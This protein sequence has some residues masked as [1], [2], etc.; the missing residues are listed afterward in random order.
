MAPPLR[1]LHIP[2]PAEGNNPH[3]IL[4]AARLQKEVGRTL[5]RG[6]VNDA[7]LPS[8]PGA[9]PPQGAVEITFK[10]AKVSISY[11]QVPLDRHGEYSSFLSLFASVGQET[12]LTAATDQG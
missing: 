11:G 6:V 7:C 5:A 8:T 3:H 9:R 12:L 10:F 1:H 4:R 2:S